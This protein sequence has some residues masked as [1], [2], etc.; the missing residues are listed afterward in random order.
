VV[1]PTR[2]GEFSLDVA[3]MIYPGDWFALAASDGTAAFVG[4]SPLNVASLLAS[5]LEGYQE[6][7]FPCPATPVVTVGIVRSPVIVGVP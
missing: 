1:C 5:G 6:T 7:A 2:Y 4:E 3:T